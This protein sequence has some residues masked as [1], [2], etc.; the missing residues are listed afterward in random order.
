[1]VFGWAAA[2]DSHWQLV[3]WNDSQSRL[4]VGHE[5]GMEFARALIFSE[6]LFLKV[7]GVVCGR[8]V[9]RGIKFR[10]AVD[11]L[12]KE[13]VICVQVW[14]GFLTAQLCVGF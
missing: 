1:M 11:K 7:H 9:T 14:Y 4:E 8:N 3:V 6:G 5:V 13:F 12:K 10:G 2:I